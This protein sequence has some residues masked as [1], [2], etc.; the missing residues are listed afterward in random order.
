MSQ[1][2][3]LTVGGK[4][5]IV[6]KFYPQ[7]PI[8]AGRSDPVSPIWTKISIMKQ[9]DHKNKPVNAFLKFPKIDL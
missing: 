2:C 7:N 1:N 8:L 9:L 5:Q 4:G 6:T 3:P